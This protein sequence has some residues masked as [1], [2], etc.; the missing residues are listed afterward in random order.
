MFLN[1]K[2]NDAVEKILIRKNPEIN[3]NSTTILTQY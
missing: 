2:K 3:L 1:I